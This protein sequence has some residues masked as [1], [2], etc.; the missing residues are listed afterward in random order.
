MDIGFNHVYIKQ[1]QRFSD[2]THELRGLL[3]PIKGY[4]HMPLVSLEE[5]VIPLVPILPDIHTYVFMAKNNCSIPP[6][7]GLTLD[8]SASICLYS[9]E[10][11]PH[12]QCLG[13]E[14][15]RTL[16]LKDRQQLNPWCLYLKLILT[17]LTHLPSIHNQIIYRGIKLDLSKDYPQGKKFIWWGFSS[18]TSSLS[19][20]ESMQFIGKTG[21]RTMFIIECI[22]GKDISKHTFF[23]SEQEVL[24]LPAT[25]FIVISCENKPKGLHIIHLKEIEPPFTLLEPIIVS[26]SS[27]S[28]ESN[29][30]SIRKKVPI[31]NEKLEQNRW[32]NDPNSTYWNSKLEKLIYENEFSS[33]MNLSQE[34][35]IDHDIP[36]IIEQ[37]IINKQCTILD[38]T[39]NDI[40]SEGAILL[41]DALNNNSTLKELIL[42]NNRIGDKGVRALALELSINNSTLK[43][44][45]LGFNDITDDG[46][47]HLAQMLKTNRTLTHLWLQQNHIGDRG[48]QLLAGVLARQNWS[49]QFLN[50]FSNKFSSDLSVTA[51][52]DMLQLNQSLQKLDIDDCNLTDT[53]EVKL[54]EIIKTKKDFEL[55]I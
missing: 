44:L 3:M 41:A 51:L 40:T 6:A 12:D 7:D 16:R 30:P 55:I 15:N 38:L 27:L 39:G 11:R 34:Q 47:Q 54:R 5:S 31:V 45:N 19:V 8:E 9:I 13:H 36:I 21:I 28:I 33:S 46:A 24:I 42:Y 53:S 22:S 49:L 35:L 20:L 52:I 32:L 50:L 43:T 23:Q 4:E 29:S 2:I 14:L 26:N 25:R 1:N 48:I 37:A 17:A 18:C 10:W